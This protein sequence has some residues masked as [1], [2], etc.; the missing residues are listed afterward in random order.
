[1][2]VT[3]EMASQL[4]YQLIL[5]DVEYIVAPYEADAQIAYLFHHGIVEAVLTED[6]DL[7]PFG[8]KKVFYK[9]DGNGDGF[10][11]DM[12]QLERAKKPSF[13]G[14]TKKDLLLS[15]V[16]GG[17]DYVES[18][19]GMGYRTAQKFVSKNLGKSMDS[20]LDKLNKETQ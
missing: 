8:C 9:M 6:S 15:C 5:M 17:C 7:I 18:L 20:L 1:M 12:D 13:E 14:F 19:K 10:E 16:I 2:D 3:P 11:I 4:I